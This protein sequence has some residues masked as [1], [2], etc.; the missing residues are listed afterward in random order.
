VSAAATVAAPVRELAAAQPLDWL[1]R[2]WRDFTRAPLPSVLH[3]VLFLAAGAAIVAVGWGRVWLLAG[4][5]SGFLRVAP[6]LAAGLYEVSRRLARGE[7]PTVRDVIRVWIE[8]GGCM[9]RLGLLL[10]LLGTLWVALSAAI[11]VGLGGGAGGGVGDFL[12]HFVLS[13]NWL[14]FTLWLVAGGL[15]AAIVFAISVVSVPMLLDRDVNLPVA[16]LTSVRVVGTNPATMTLWAGLVMLVTM[17]GIA[18]VLPMVV[19]VPVL[20]HAT[21]HAYSDSVDAAGLAPRL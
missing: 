17:A 21:W 19:L 2:G 7:Q 11:I 4:A 18:L 8:G 15:F 13:P 16:A 20:G 3:G 10:A 9:V 6:M 1:A 12:R 5:F 14:P